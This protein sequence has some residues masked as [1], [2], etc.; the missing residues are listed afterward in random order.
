MTD[1]KNL[2]PQPSE[3]HLSAETM[4]EYLEGHLSPGDSHQAEQHL[5]DCE[6]CAEALEGLSLLPPDQTRHALFDLNRSIKNRSLKRKPNRLMNDLKSWALVTAILFLLVF[7]GIIVWYQ[8]SLQDSPGKENQIN[9]GVET[10]PTPL[11][12]HQAYSQYLQN[13]QQYPAAALRQQLSGQV[14]LQFWVN[15]DSTLSDIRVLQGPEGGLRQEAL[16]LLRQGPVWLPA[17]QNGSPVRARAQVRVD[18]RLP[19]QSNM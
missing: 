3:G 1:L 17:R 11:G 9:P 5:L 18:F 19:Q 6:L 12:G 2:N 16:R 8:T 10:A 4:V 15:P 13:S 7:S 14:V